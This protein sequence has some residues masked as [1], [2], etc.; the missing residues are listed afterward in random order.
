MICQTSS[1]L[2][3]NIY[4]VFLQNLCEIFGVQGSNLWITQTEPAG[5]VLQGPVQGSGKVS[6]LEVEAHLDLEF[7]GRAA[8]HEI[9]RREVF[10]GRKA[11]LG[12]FI[13]VMFLGT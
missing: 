6:L 5:P 10:G 7:V 1:S 2:L 9:K 12:S 13:V 3:N 11:L 4:N 8:P